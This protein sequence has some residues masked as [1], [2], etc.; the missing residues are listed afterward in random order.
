MEA[1]LTSQQCSLI[2]RSLSRGNVFH[3]RRVPVSHVRKVS[4]LQSLFYLFSSFF[5]YPLPSPLRLS[6]SLSLLFFSLLFIFF[7]FS[8]SCFSTYSN[9]RLFWVDSTL[10]RIMSSSINGSNVQTIALSGGFLTLGSFVRIRTLY[11]TYICTYTLYCT[12]H[13]YI[14]I[15]LYLHTCSVHTF[16]GSMYMSQQLGSEVE[17]QGTANKSTTPRTALSFQRKEEELPWVG[18]EPTTLCSLGERT[19][20]AKAKHKSHIHHHAYNT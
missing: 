14:H 13:M 8:L 16:T 20:K 5:F 6:L 18:F 3:E 1:Q 2:V 7:S 10:L 9:G 15:V 17:R 12:L 19:S 4:R 11:C